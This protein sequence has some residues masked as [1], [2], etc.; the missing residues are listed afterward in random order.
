MTKYN[1][2]FELSV[3]DLEI[4]ETALRT[5][6]RSLA[7]RRMRVMQTRAAPKTEEA[8]LDTLEVDLRTIHD[9]LG[10]LH[11]QKTFYRPGGI[12]YVGG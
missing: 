10:R 1:T 9:L 2:N 11:N 3:E 4:I 6:K 7:D 12:P 5:Q 8:A